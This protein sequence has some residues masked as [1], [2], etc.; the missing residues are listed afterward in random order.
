MYLARYKIIVTVGVDASGE[1]ILG[2]SK[3]WTYFKDTDGKV[4]VFSDAFGGVAYIG[5]GDERV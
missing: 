3:A 1:S 5:D 2:S 4:L